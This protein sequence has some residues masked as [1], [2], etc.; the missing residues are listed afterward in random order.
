[1]W[2]DI[3]NLNL[4]L[5]SST[6]PQPM[7]NIT[8]TICSTLLT[9]GALS[10]QDIYI[11][12]KAGGETPTN[13]IP[14]LQFAMSKPGAI[15]RDTA[16]DIYFADED[17]NTVYMV[18]ASTG[19]VTVVAGNGQKGFYG[20]KGAATA[21]ELNQPTGVAVDEQGNVYISDMG[22]NRI[23]KVN[24]TGIIGTVAGNGKAG[25]KGD[26]GQADTA[27]FNKPMSVAVDG[28][29]NLFIADNGND[30]IREVVTSGNIETIVGDGKASFGGDGGRAD[31]AKLN[32]PMCVFVDVSN[33]IYIAD[34]GNNRIRKVSAGNISTIAGDGTKGFSGDGSAAALAEL[35]APQAVTV[36]ANGTIYIADAGNNRLR[37]IN[38]SGIINTVAGTGTPGYNGDMQLGTLAQVNMPAGLVADD[39]GNV[40]VAD[41]GNGRIRLVNFR[42][43]TIT[44][45]A[46]GSI[47]DGQMANFAV[48]SLPLAV[49]VDSASNV[50]IADMGYNRVRR[51]SGKTDTITT[52]AGSGHAGF[53]GDGG[54]ADTAQLNS[55]SG[56]A[57]GDSGNIYIADTKNN[58]IRMVSVATGII[59]TVAGNGV[60]GYSGDGGSA[61]SAELNTPEGVATDASHNIYIAD[62]YNNR[63]R[64]IDYATG[65]ITTVAGNGVLAWK[66]D[67]GLATAASMAAP[68]AISFDGAGNMY[69]CD[70]A[71]FRIRKVKASN[72]FIYTIAG[73][74]SN[75]G[76][77]IP[78]ST[79]QLNNPTGIAS[80]SKGDVYIADKADQLIREIIGDSSYT[81]GGNGTPG[82]TGDGGPALYAELYYPAGLAL[83]ANDDLFIADEY[84]DRVREMSPKPLGINEVISNNEKVKVYPNPSSGLFTFSF[85]H[86]VPSTRDQG[87]HLTVYN[88]L[89]EMI[90]D[91]ALRQAQGDYQI[92][93]GNESHG[94]YF[95]RIISE[96]SELI[97][98]GKL[99]I[100]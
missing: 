9:I 13:N 45:F 84:N 62:T 94:I 77:G 86:P 61:L 1:L 17:N 21:A 40:Y 74:G 24:K 90:F 16:G 54:M 38:K 22:N 66:G 30:V 64:K 99:L 83:D 41:K 37:A 31:T 81:I 4:N 49:A 96:K 52:L 11:S 75:T 55:P 6:K 34:A 70:W 97:G 5:S 18:S 73:G 28:G 89:G 20:D 19:N 76:S 69:I 43:D 27:E 47:G 10:A 93:L 80:D 98:S 15:A 46:G 50:F 88:E 71:N 35:D 44:T 57:V 91:E 14:A 87:S 85:S 2:Q 29:G 92:N 23:R 100:Q 78:A 63:I 53:Y 25:Y 60:G 79:L 12:T 59:T 33:N 7:K 65:I 36:S 51:V 82:C 48:L 42:T 8:L 67:S 72:K 58:R 32:S 95:Y 26:G 3:L 56:V 68:T 39:S